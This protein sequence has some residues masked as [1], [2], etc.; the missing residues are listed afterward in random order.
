IGVEVVP[1]DEVAD[2]ADEDRPETAAHLRPFAAADGR[3]ALNEFTPARVLHGRHSALPDARTGTFAPTKLLVED[4]RPQV[5]PDGGAELAQLERIRV[6]AGDSR[7]IQRQPAFD[8]ELAGL[9]LVA[10]IVAA[11]R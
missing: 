3:R 2:R 9:L 10:G 11:E 1:L 5:L 7:I 8:E 6:I 4:L